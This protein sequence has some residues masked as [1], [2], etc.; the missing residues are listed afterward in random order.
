[1][2]RYSTTSSAAG[3][4]TSLTA[5]AD[6]FPLPINTNSENILKS[7]I[8]GRRAW[9]TSRN[10]EAVWPPELEA[11]LLEGLERYQPDDY[12]APRKPGRCPWRNRFISD[13]IFDKT[14][15]RRS[16]KQVGSRLQQ[17]RN[18]CG[19]ELLSLLSPMRRRPS[20]SLEFTYN[21][22]LN[23][24][25]SPVSDGLC[26]SSSAHDDT[27]IYIDILPKV[28]LDKTRPGCSSSAWSDTGD[29]VRASDSPHLE[30]INPIIA[31]TSLSPIIAHSRFTVYSEDLI[32][33]AEMVPLV[34]LVDL[35]Q[36][37]GPSGFLYTT[38]L[39]PK[40]WDVISDSRDPTTFTIF[41]EVLKEN[42]SS[43]LFSATYKF[44]YPRYSKNPSESH[45]SP[46]RPYNTQLPVDIPSCHITP[47]RCPMDNGEAQELP[48]PHVRKNYPLECYP[49][50]ANDSCFPLELSN[51]VL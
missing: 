22:F 25:I 45:Q 2:E 44:R 28:S 17:L 39:V 12:R 35:N 5:S 16:S 19:G 47:Y 31:F 50:R 10:G 1:D 40:Y 13:Y 42:D 11:A 37:P 33:H 18:S 24:P 21:N 23:S 38:R 41:Q 34:L 9:K 14:G 6:L 27:V 8:R 43:I 32:L 7:V 51:Y 36:A 48:L 29:L 20:F 4:S 15:I 3:C 49:S 46:C 26:P 30:S